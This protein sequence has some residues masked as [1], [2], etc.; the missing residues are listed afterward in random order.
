MGTAVLCFLLSLRLETVFKTKKTFENQLFKYVLR[1][2][3]KTFFE[4]KISARIERELKRNKL[5]TA[6][7]L[8]LKLNGPVLIKPCNIYVNHALPV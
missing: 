8:G 2:F 4:K 3:G 5:K 1:Y 6:F 7:L